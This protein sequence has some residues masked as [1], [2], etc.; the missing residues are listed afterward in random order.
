MVSARVRYNE[1]W[2]SSMSRPRKNLE[3]SVS[4]FPALSSL[5]ATCWILVA[6]TASKEQKKKEKE[7]RRKRRNRRRG[8]RREGRNR[9][10]RKEG[11]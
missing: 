11:R 10:K 2:S 8:G 3:R 4:I 6:S 9:K 5:I 1:L 7:R